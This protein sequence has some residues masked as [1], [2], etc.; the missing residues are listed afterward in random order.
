MQ[1]HSDPLK[2]SAANEIILGSERQFFNFVTIDWTGDAN[3]PLK[4]VSRYVSSINKDWALSGSSPTEITN[5]DGSSAAQLT[6][7][8]AGDYDGRS[9]ASLLSPYQVDSLFWGVEPLG[10]EII[11][12]LGVVTP[13][14]NVFYPQFVGNIT[15]ISPNRGE[16]SVEIVALDR[17][18][19]MR[20][21]VMFPAWAVSDLQ[22]NQGAVNS[23]LVD[24]S[25]VID[26]CLRICDVSPTPYCH[27]N[28]R[29]LE[30]PEDDITGPQLWIS[31]TGAI[32]PTIGWPDNSFIQQFPLDIDTP[33]M[34]DES[35]A[36]H[37]D[38]PEPAQTTLALEAR[39][40]GNDTGH[41]YYVADRDRLS[42]AGSQLLAFTLITADN[43]FL[44][45]ADHQV[46]N[47]R[48][49]DNIVLK[50]L[51]GAGQVWSERTN[52]ITAV[53]V[54]TPKLNIPT[55][56]PWVRITCIWDGYKAAGA[57][58]F[59]QAGS[60]SQTSVGAVQTHSS[61]GD[62]F[63]GL[64]NINTTLGL[65]DIGV[66]STNFGGIAS[67][68]FTNMI[69]HE[70]AYPAVLDRGLNRIS[71]I[72]NRN[73]ADAWQIVTDV[74]SSEFGSV[75]WDEEGVFRFW[76]LDRIRNLQGELT[77]TYTLDNVENLDITRMLD[78]IRNVWTVS[79][80]RKRGVWT[81]TIVAND[82]NQFVIPHRTRKLFKIWQNDVQITQP[83]ILP[84]YS[85][86]VGNPYGIPIW[87]NNV[88][89]GYVV[90]YLVAGV[91]AENDAKVS[92]LDILSYQDHEGNIIVNIWNGWDE[93]ARLA[94]DT[95]ESTLRI[96]GTKIVGLDPVTTTHRQEDSIDQYDVR[97]LAI[98]GDWYQDS[99]DAN[100]M[101]EKLLDRT[102][103]PVPT[104]DSITVAGDPRIQLGDMIRIKD[105]DGFGSQF[106]AQIYGIN[107]TYTLTEGLKDVLT[108]QLVRPGSRWD[109]PES[110][111][112]ENNFVWS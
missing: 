96:L 109:D 42:S 81:R 112:W 22:A 89:D 6:L 64:V 16:N 8:L 87:N 73:Y 47:Y 32:V 25:W 101:S 44:T 56:Q 34:Y 35:G 41:S 26:H 21:A 59:L 11:W 93:T 30:L 97:N 80:E 23:Q 33:A 45:V 66:V 40:V 102:S 5:I 3:H 85:T 88:N 29:Y 20:K 99:Y 12:Q 19:K 75:F 2:E 17:A 58:C 76:N 78:G 105:S 48:S 24:S 70:A 28:R 49:S 65:Q 31:G 111:I 83:G 50:V 84:R 110:A 18:E 1:S 108:V 94:A 4:N 54:T 53:T 61:S 7:T 103:W 67:S 82:I 43:A 79:T 72:P 37:P 98:T 13:L 14:G 15:M 107:R 51:V 74:A 92:G 38:S 71:F 10:V 62:I 60:A 36:V 57:T 68:G 52:E 55:G 100:G 77:R 95:G 104:T 91:W 9:L 39:G 27:S 46:L 63:K 69:A 90:Q 106:D 86:I